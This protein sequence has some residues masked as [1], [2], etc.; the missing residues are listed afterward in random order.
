M[1]NMDSSS[2]FGILFLIFLVLIY[3]ER[4]IT[5]CLLFCQKILINGLSEDIL[6]CFCFCLYD[7]TLH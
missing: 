4:G 2:T 7:P 1:V 5:N 3:C 6:N